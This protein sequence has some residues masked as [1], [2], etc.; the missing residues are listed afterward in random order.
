[1]FLL[2]LLVTTLAW[3]S[4]ETMRTGQG[5]NVDENANLLVVM[6]IRE[7]ILE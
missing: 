6:L 7:N 5:V 2:S 1:M 4:M 3:Q